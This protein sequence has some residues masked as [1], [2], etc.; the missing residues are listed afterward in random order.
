MNWLS[1]LVKSC[2][3][4]A[5]LDQHYEPN[6]SGYVVIGAGLPR[7]GTMSMKSALGTLLNAPCYHMLNVSSGNE[8]DLLHWQKA[9]D[10]EMFSKED[11]INF[12]PKRGFRAGVDFPISH[13][14]KELMD[15]FP[16]AKVILT[17]RDP[18]KWYKSA[19]NSIMEIRKSSH[20][21]HVQFFLQLIGGYREYTLVNE[22]SNTTPLNGCL[23]KGMWD[24][25]DGGETEAIKAYN[26]WVDEVKRIVPKEKLLVFD[27]KE[28]WGPLCKFLDCP[29][30]D[31]NF[32]HVNDT[33]SMIRS[34]KRLCRISFFTIYVLPCIIVVFTA[35]FSKAIGFF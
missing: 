25:V 34:N 1:T 13:F 17:N 24:Y 21:L 19:K 8:E 11:W 32:P 5:A 28:G 33:P 7:T 15:V 27:V 29:V 20:F 14:Y 6:Y 23:Q 18:E 30:P 3:G 26:I 16:N 4:D 2:A 22:S 31:T 9:V 10:G 12:L 35:L